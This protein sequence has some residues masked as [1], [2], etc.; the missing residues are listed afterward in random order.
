VEFAKGTF[1]VA[2]TDLGVPILELAKRV[3]TTSNLPDDLRSGLD[4]TA[5]FT[6]PQ[7]SFPNGCHV[8]EVEIDPQTGMVAVVG[9]VAVDDVGTVIHETIV[10]GQTHGGIAQGLGQVLG[11]Q[12]R[13]G[14]DGQLLNASFMDYAMPRADGM[15]HMTTALH[16]VPC[17]NNPLGVKGAGESGVA[18]SLPSAMN[19][20]IDALAGAGIEHIDL[21]ASPTRVWEAL[22]AAGAN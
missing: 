14:E 20:I 7:M 8:C 12:V 6:S 13:Y 17:T 19:A 18:G 5:E 15:P 11:E 2:G 22:S 16:V 3:R 10:D 21:P 9:Y 4:S 1:S